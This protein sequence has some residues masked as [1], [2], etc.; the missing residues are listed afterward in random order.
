MASLA[1]DVLKYHRNK[2]L[3]RC[4]SNHLQL[5]P[6]D[7]S[8][9]HSFLTT[10]EDD[11]SESTVQGRESTAF[12]LSSPLLS[13]KSPEHDPSTPQSQI[14]P[15]P[16]IGGEF[17]DE[18]LTCSPSMKMI[19]NLANLYFGNV[20]NLPPIRGL[21]IHQLPGNILAH[22]FHYLDGLSIMQVEQVSASWKRICVAYDQ[23]LWKS[24]TESL[25]LSRLEWNR[26]HVDDQHLLD[27]IRRLSLSALKKG[28][29]GVD[30]SRC[31]EKLDFQL[32]LQAHLLFYPLLT[33]SSSITSPSS[34]SRSRRQSY[35]PSDDETTCCTSSDQSS[36]CSVTKNENSGCCHCYYPN[37]ALVIKEYKASYMYALRECQRE[38]RS[39]LCHFGEDL[40]WTSS[41]NDHQRQWKIVEKE[42]DRF[43]VKIQIDSYP[44]LTVHRER[45]GLQRGR[46]KLANDQCLFL[47]EES[48]DSIDMPLF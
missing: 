37:W 11:H 5:S 46:W 42:D 30:V 35:G 36:I 38:G 43:I 6:N 18:E 4:V 24:L 12:S 20:Q 9:S 23:L 2:G 14:M 44:V 3:S 39:F 33:Q 17:V 47:Q 25:W 7:R 1:F 26:P 28:L 45:Y 32:A 29:V 31:I 41:M 15:S 19:V 34:P 27:R 22:I 21:I 16:R 48:I 8:R 13:A 40:S 10:S